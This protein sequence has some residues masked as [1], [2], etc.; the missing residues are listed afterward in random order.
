MYILLISYYLETKQCDL[1]VS[2]PADPT[3]LTIVWPT[4]RTPPQDD[5]YNLE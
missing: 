1:R 5:S 4:K 2:K 3:G